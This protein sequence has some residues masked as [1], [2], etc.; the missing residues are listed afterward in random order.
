MFV[1][2]I[3]LI[4][5]QTNSQCLHENSQEKVTEQKELLEPVEVTEVEH[6]IESRDLRVNIV[7][8]K[9]Q[10]THL[11]LIENVKAKKMTKSAHL[12][13]DMQHSVKETVRFLFLIYLNLYV[14]GTRYGSRDMRKE[15]IRK[16]STQVGTCHA[17]VYQTYPKISDIISIC[18][19]YSN[20]TFVIPMMV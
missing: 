19:L 12:L 5:D 14:L 6:I 4:F 20:K 8:K 1:I 9:A 7:P 15:G 13:G 3:F 16:L 17:T 11:K 2:L 18:L 10:S